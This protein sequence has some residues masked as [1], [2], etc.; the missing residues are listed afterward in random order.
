MGL[1][2]VFGAMMNRFRI[3][4]L[5]AALSPALVNA[6][7]A[8]GAPPLIAIRFNQPYVNYIEQLHGALSKAVAVKPT[9]K[10]EL[11]SLAPTTGD[12]AR[13]SQWQTIAGRNTKMVLDTMLAMGVPAQR[14]SVRGKTAPGL[15]FDETHVFVQ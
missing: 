8:P 4:L 14:I 10:I 12:A 7:D 5:L 1:S 6:A 9:V 3:F 2:I 13:D 15:A 11:V